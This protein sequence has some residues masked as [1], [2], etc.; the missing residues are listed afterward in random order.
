MRET[1]LAEINEK[2]LNLLRWYAGV[3]TIYEKTG[4]YVLRDD[5]GAYVGELKKEGEETYKIVFCGNMYKEITEGVKRV[6]DVAERIPCKKLKSPDSEIKTSIFS[7][8]IAHYQ[9]NSLRY[10]A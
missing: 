2:Y 5:R 4:G 10:A 3:S 6:K 8:Q 1:F 9:R 7:R